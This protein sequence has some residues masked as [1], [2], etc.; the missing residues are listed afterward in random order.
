LLY[1]SGEYTDSELLLLTS[2]QMDFVSLRTDCNL[3]LSLWMLRDI[4]QI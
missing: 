4:N 3:Q 1:E 2:M